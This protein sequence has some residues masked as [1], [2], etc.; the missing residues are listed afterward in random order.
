MCIGW[1]FRKIFMNFIDYGEHGAFPL[2]GSKKL[3]HYQENKENLIGASLLVVS[4]Y[5]FHDLSLIEKQLLATIIIIVFSILIILI[6]IKVYKN[7][8]KD[9]KAIIF[10]DTCLYIALFTFA[11]LIVVQSM[12]TSLNNVHLLNVMVQ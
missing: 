7:S 12:I 9:K 4:T 5:N 6:N 2:V 1:F 11:V 3:E 10:K 8:N